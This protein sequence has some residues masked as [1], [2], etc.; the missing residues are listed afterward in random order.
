MTATQIDPRLNKTLGGLRDML[1]EQEEVMNERKALWDESRDTVSKLRRAIEALDPQPKEP[2]A[3]ANGNGQAGQSGTMRWKPSEEIRTRV[4]A[5]M[6]GKG[7]MT[8]PE[9]AGLAGVADETVRRT[10]DWGRA[11][12]DPPVR[13]AGVSKNNA[14]MY[15]SLEADV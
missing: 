7:K 10:M 4:L 11:Q 15:E 12:A 2:R 1:A 9:I 5:A 3:T 14:K 6:K 13:F 8:V